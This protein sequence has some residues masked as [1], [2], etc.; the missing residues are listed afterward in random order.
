MISNVNAPPSNPAPTGGNVPELMKIGAIPINTAQ[1]VETKILEP[2]VKTDSFCRFVFSN[3]GLLHSHSKVEIGLN[4]APADAVFPINVGAYALIQRVALKVG[5]QTLCEVDDFADY[6][7]YRSMFIANENQKEREQ[8][9]TGRALSHQVIYKD[10]GTTD[11]GTESNHTG[12]GIGL[13]NGRDYDVS[14]ALVDG[15]GELIPQDWQQLQQTSANDTSRWQLSLSELC[16]FLRHNQLP[17]YLFKEQ[18]ALELTFSKV[19]SS[20]HASERVSVGNGGSIT[21]AYTIDTDALR[22]ISDHIFYPQEMMISY[23]NANKVLNFTYADY[24]LSKYSQDVATA[25]TQQIRNIGGAGRIVSKILWGMQNNDDTST[26]INNKYNAWACDRTYD[27]ASDANNKNGVATFNIKYNDTFEF[28]ID[29]KNTARH[30]HNVNQA[31]GMVPFITREEFGNEGDIL[32]G[33]KWLNNAQHTLS[34]KF[35][36]CSSR[37]GKQERINSRGIELYFQL[38][39]LPASTAGYVQRVY[40]EVMRT[41]TLTNGYLECYYA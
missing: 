39:D 36:W 11:G 16:P 20:A 13:D 7:S 17:L 5:N 38:E 10:R 18:V 24:R 31:E 26:S 23:A 30:F 6:F 34:G 14:G 32:T 35:F 22:L 21:D 8:M 2:V 27:D 4:N 15:T 25:K 28:P 19:G 41:A 9:T 3:A 29:V 33:R 37:L 12:S 1:E 40:L